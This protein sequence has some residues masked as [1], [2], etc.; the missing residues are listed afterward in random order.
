VEV[1]SPF[2]ALLKAPYLAGPF[3]LVA[4]D[5]IQTFLSCNILCEGAS[6]KISDALV[7]VVE[8]VSKCKF[9]ET[10]TIGDEQVQLQIIQTLKCILLSP[11]RR[12]LT[13]S[14]SWTIVEFSFQLLL[15]TGLK[16][17]NV[18]GKSSLYYNLERLLL[19]AVRFVFAVN[20]ES[21]D[22]DND[23]KSVN[24]KLGSP[25]QIDHVNTDY[26]SCIGL[27]CALKVFGF[28]INILHKHS[29]KVVS[30]EVATK[31]AN[32][33]KSTS[34]NMRSFVPLNESTF[35]YETLELLIALKS[36][37]AILL[38]EGGQ[39]MKSRN[40]IMLCPPL[41]SM[42]RDDLGRYLV[43]LCTNRNFSPSILQTSLGIFT[44][45]L[46]SIGPSMRLLVECFMKHVYLKSLHQL[47]NAFTQYEESLYGNTDI[48]TTIPIQEVDVFST[49]ELELILESLS[50][51]ISDS[52]FLPSLFAS[53][54]CDPTK[55]D[56]IQPLIHYLSRSTRVYL[57]IRS[58]DLGHLMELGG[59]CMNCYHHITRTITARGADGGRLHSVGKIINNLSKEERDKPIPNIDKKEVEIVAVAQHLQSTR[60]SKNLLLQASK[61]F[62]DKPQECFIF[63]Q[64]HGA[65]P[66][67]LTPSSVAKFL[68]IAPGLP[69]ENTGKLYLFNH[70]YISINY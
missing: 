31:A 21:K 18:M 19:D 12:Y 13:D 44:S 50:D 9:I 6:G 69:K 7:D 40:I 56:I 62:I 17:E 55:P 27:P 52:G 11:V 35:D 53:F 16:E 48:A 4:L 66:T 39:M 61:L 65:L 26:Q 3:K 25:L 59:L 58:K 2:L 43:L 23:N 70:C 67:P 46:I 38:A 5:S 34:G 63:L 57:I 45:L 20:L 42:V 14:S 68:R 49:E 8:V 24:S 30:N 41:A 32:V 37:Q 47:L 33:S 54:D 51:L 15:Q 36:I 29:N 64:S 1:I 22:N 10:D 60:F 28:F